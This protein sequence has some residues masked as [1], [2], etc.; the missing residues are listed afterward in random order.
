M[1]NYT[2]KDIARIAGVGVTTVSRVLNNGY[3]V[4]KETRAKVMEVIEKCNYIPNSNAKHLKQVTSQIVCIIVKG[5]YNPFFHDMVVELQKCVEAEGYIPLVSYIDEDENEIR[6]ANQLIKEK[7]AQ[8]IIFLGGSAVDKEEEL[9]KLN[10]PCVYATSSASDCNVSGVSSVSIDD[11][12]EARR[13]VTYLLDSGHKN[14][15]VV[16]GAIY[17]KDLMY[18]RYQGV[19]EAFE[20]RGMHFDKKNMY[21]ESKFSYAAAYESMSSFLKLNKPITAVFAMSDVMAIGIAKCVIDHG[22]KVPEDISI[23]GFDGIEQAWFYNPT[24]TTIKQPSVEIAKKS[25]ALLIKTI[26]DKAFS[27]HLTVSGKLLKGNSVKV[28]S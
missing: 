5:T 19:L 12:L 26:R 1:N 27:Q 6:C 17:Q 25:V 15:L 23:I 4:S 7:K 14:I 20:E 11:C 2:I 24:I 8:G 22:L 16:G 21:I 28:M 9:H 3:G 13:A 10:S 18:N